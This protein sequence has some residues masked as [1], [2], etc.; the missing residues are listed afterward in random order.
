MRAHRV[1]GDRYRDGATVH[2][3]IHVADFRLADPPDA[4]NP[5]DFPFA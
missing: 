5:V 1:N 2:R 4:A 3:F